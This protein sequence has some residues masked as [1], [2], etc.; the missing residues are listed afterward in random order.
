VHRFWITVMRGGYAGHGET[1]ADPDDLIWWSKG[2]K[3][4]GESWQ[5]IAFLR[6][7]MEEAGTRGLEPMGHNDEWPWSRVSGARDIGGK[8]SWIYL[9]EHQ[10]DQ[11]TTGL[12]TD[13]GTYDVDVIDT[14]AM[15][16]E[17]AEIIPPYIPYPQRHGEVI[18]GGKPDADFGV[19]LP[20]RPRLALRIRRV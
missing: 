3:L 8:V 13:G 2:G 14:W 15:T 11:W 9:G 4:H 10:P 6:K 7:L 12:P 1:Y 19:R 20:A 5:R 17:K 16:V 18:R